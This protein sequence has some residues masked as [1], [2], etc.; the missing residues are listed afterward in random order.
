[1][2]G[3]RYDTA[4]ICTSGHPINCCSVD[5]PQHNME[6]CD[7]CGVPTVTECRYCG[8]YIRGYYHQEPVFSFIY[9][10]D[11][12][13]PRFCHSCGKPYPWTEAKLKA[14]QDLVD[15]LSNLNPGD[16]ELLRSSLDDMVRE[17]P[18]ATVAAT[19]FK[20]LVAKA[21]RPAADAFRDILVDI[22]SE[23]IKKSI[24]PS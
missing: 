20:R 10:R 22:L 18:Q 15:D 5:L 13:P 11:F 9:H 3:N 1:M 12:V 17:T 14:A 2:S 23:A 6:F 4:Q 21:G 8:A 16:R 19:R 7:K 24:W